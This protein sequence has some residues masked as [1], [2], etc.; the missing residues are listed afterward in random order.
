MRAAVN[1]RQMGILA[2][3]FGPRALSFVLFRWVSF[4][5]LPYS[6][7]YLSADVPFSSQNH[8]SSTPTPAFPPPSRLACALPV[9]LCSRVIQCCARAGKRRASAGDIG[10]VRSF[11]WVSFLSSRF[12]ALL[13]FRWF[14]V[15]IS[16]VSVEGRFG[17]EIVRCLWGVCYS[18]PLAHPSASDG[19]RTRGD[20]ETLRKYAGGM[21]GEY[22]ETC[23]MR[24]RRRMIQ[25]R[26]GEFDEAKW[27]AEK[28]N[29]DA[30][31]S[32]WGGVGGY[33]RW[34]RKRRRKEG[35][36]LVSGRLVFR[37]CS[38]SC[39]CPGERRMMH[40]GADMVFVPNASR[41]EEDV[42]VGG[43]WCM[44]TWCAPSPEHTHGVGVSWIFE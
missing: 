16:S 13:S 7:S 23:I 19:G 30:L 35:R 11:I 14:S 43:R 3:F 28:W 34:G 39:S 44:R 9:R 38:R 20:A 41:C 8:L 42:E 6:P 21:R 26:G 40:R 10:G 12:F 18:P 24:A 33:S 37:S 15:I 22:A 17:G 31:H 4:S 27:E 32:L 5:P 36:M 25:R 1:A 2:Y 29:V